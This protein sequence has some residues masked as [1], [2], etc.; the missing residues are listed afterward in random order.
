MGRGLELDR[1]SRLVYRLFTMADQRLK[2][3]DRLCPPEA[4]DSDL[5]PVEGEASDE[6]LAKLTKA[7]GHP[8]RVR[9]LR[10]LARRQECLCGEIVD[11]LPWAQSTVSQHLKMLK[12]AGLVRGS[13]DGPRVCYCLS[14][15]TLRRLKALIGAL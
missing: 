6:E 1:G 15:K 14:P 13:V 3:D 5:R 2:G 9:I 4:P 10:I 8:T 11:E 7:L 12:E